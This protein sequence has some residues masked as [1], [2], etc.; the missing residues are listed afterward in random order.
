MAYILQVMTGLGVVSQDG[1]L[2]HAS[3]K[4]ISERAGRLNAK[5]K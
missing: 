2:L 3:G 4:G 5:I 1:R